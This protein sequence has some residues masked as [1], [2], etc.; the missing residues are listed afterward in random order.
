MSHSSAL[1]TRWDNMTPGE[2]F[3]QTSAAHAARRGNKDPI[4]RMMARANSRHHNLIGIGPHEIVL[5]K[6]LDAANIQYQQQVSCGKYNIDFTIGED[7]IAV[8]VCAGT[9][10][11][12]ISKRRPK[13]IEYILNSRHLVEI[14]FHT[15]YARIFSPGI[16]EKLVAFIDFARFNPPP[17][18]KYRVIRPDGE[19]YPIRLYGPSKPTISAPD[20]LIEAAIS[21]EW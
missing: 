18:G 16:I 10:N 15:G 13:R 3:H 21:K 17:P 7:L 4:W 8:E 12:R 11:S 1:K 14:R 20:Y 6:L 2:R 5:A 9:G 19:R